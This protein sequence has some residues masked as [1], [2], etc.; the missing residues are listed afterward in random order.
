MEKYSNAYQTHLLQIQSVTV[1]IEKWSKAMKKSVRKEIQ[2][3]NTHTISHARY[4]IE[5]IPIYPFLH[6]RLTKILNIDKIVL[7]VQ[8]ERQVHTL[9][10]TVSRDKTF[11]VCILVTSVKIKTQIPFYQSVSP[12]V[13]YFK[14]IQVFRNRY[15]GIH[16]CIIVL[17]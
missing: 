7:R 6:I 9:L 4:E 8:G 17:L 1:L 16:L 2:M 3:A 15:R 10:V 13:I 12:L 5:T 11:S 14:C